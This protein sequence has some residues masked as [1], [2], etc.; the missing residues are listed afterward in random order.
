MHANISRID[1]QNETVEQIAPSSE[2][3]RSRYRFLGRIASGG[4]GS[5]YLGTRTGDDERLYAIKVIHE[6]LA[7]HPEFVEMLMSEAE[8]AQ[9]LVHP[10]IVG[11]C[12]TGMF[13]ERQF[14]VMPYVEGGTLS[15]LARRGGGRIPP[16][17][18]IR[19]LIDVLRGLHAAHALTD[20]E[21]QPLGLVHR[22]VSPGNILIGTDG[23]ARII[24]FGVAK[25]SAKL[26]RTAPGVVKGKFS[27]MAPEQAQGQNIDCRADVFSAGVVLW[28]AL[29]GKPLFT[30]ENDAQTLKNMLS[31][32]IPAP[33][34]VCPNSPKELD[35]ICV[36]A[37]Q[38]EQEDRFRSAG[39]FAE[40]LFSAAK[41]NGLVASAREV[42]DLVVAAFAQRVTRRRELVEHTR[43]SRTSADGP[44]IER[45]DVS[46]TSPTLFYERPALT[47]S[48]P[49][50]HRR[51]RSAHSTSVT[52]VSHLGAMASPS[53]STVSLPQFASTHRAKHA[54]AVG[55][56]AV[57]AIAAITILAALAVLLGN[58]ATA[59]TS[60][61]QP[62]HHRV[63]VSEPVTSNTS[64]VRS[65]LLEAT[66]TADARRD[67][68]RA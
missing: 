42:S 43:A 29:T 48:Y 24:D 67:R 45:Q 40:S 21:G 66:S 51:A 60:P 19:I 50:I 10:N 28:T 18:T 56:W 32:P 34:E 4:M 6:H 27:Y 41:R 3:S 53:I 20:D 2:A 26:P 36:R 9:N 46:E 8:T 35:A 16:A 47:P 7:D 15:E 37:L 39:E 54:N 59:S 44:E 11:V 25:L 55:T 38:R 33:S 64:L 52:P 68:P 14:V 57:V 17:V 58:R 1:A 65:A 12:D 5:V 22:D 23:I 31:A 62:S 13:E 30:G 63:S 49:P 61:F